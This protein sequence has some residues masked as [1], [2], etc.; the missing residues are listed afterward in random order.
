MM[1][2]RIALIAAWLQEF[3]RQATPY[4]IIAGAALLY[5]VLK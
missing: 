1:E 2:G 4:A 5:W 3:G